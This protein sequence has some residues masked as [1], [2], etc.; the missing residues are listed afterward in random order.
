MLEL[1][2]YLVFG[3][4]FVYGLV[5]VFKFSHELDKTRRAI[6]R[7]AQIG[8]TNGVLNSD[9]FVDIIEIIDNTHTVKQLN[10]MRDDLQRRVG[11]C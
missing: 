9:N 11:Q 4:G 1:L 10:W 3:F 6:V 5:W 8:L 7:L 2:M